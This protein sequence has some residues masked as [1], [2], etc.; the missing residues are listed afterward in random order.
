MNVEI[1]D[2]GRVYS[3]MKNSH[4]QASVDGRTE[5]LDW[6][7]VPDNLVFNKVYLHV[8]PNKNFKI[9]YKLSKNVV[10]ITNGVGYWIFNKSGLN[11]I[12]MLEE[13]LFKI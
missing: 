12:S 11:E 9:V 6:S 8:Q 1:I 7:E 10:I 13:D 4:P 3:T 2:C 5:L